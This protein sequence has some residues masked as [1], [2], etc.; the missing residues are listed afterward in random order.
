[1]IIA[2]SCM[3]SSTAFSINDEPTIVPLASENVDCMGQRSGLS[4][5]D[6]G[7]RNSIYSSIIMLSHGAK[8]THVNL[9]QRLL[10]KL[11]HS[12]GPIDGLLFS[13]TR[14]NLQL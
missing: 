6:A 2:R 8:G 5:A 14:L 7:V 1:M 11:N 12:P 3:T 13:E 4:Q 9:L 10:L